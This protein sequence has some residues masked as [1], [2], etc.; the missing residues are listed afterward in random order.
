MI[1]FFNL[2]I[3]SNLTH[4]RN[5]CVLTSAQIASVEKKAKKVFGTAMFEEAENSLSYTPSPSLIKKSKATNDT[6]FS[7]DPAPA[8]TILFAAQTFTGQ[9]TAASD[10]SDVV[11]K[12]NA[13][14][15]KTFEMNNAAKTHTPSSSLPLIAA[16]SKRREELNRLRATSSQSP[17]KRDLLKKTLSAINIATVSVNKSLNTSKNLKVDVLKKERAIKS[18]KVRFQWKEECTQA[19]SF[20]EAAENSRRQFLSLKRT[21]TSKHFKHKSVEDQVKRRQNIQEKEKESHFNSEVFRDHHEALKAERDIQRRQSMEA[22]AKLREN[23]KAGEQRLKM[24]QIEEE[25]AVIEARHD[26]STARRE[27]IKHSVVQRRK[28]FAFRGGDARRI[29]QLRSKWT[30]EHEDQKHSDFELQ[31]QAARDAAN[32]KKEMEKARRESL[33]KR[34]AKARSIRQDEKNKAAAAMVAEHESYQ[35]KFAGEKD[36]EEYQLRI[37]SER[38]KSLANRNK[39]SA[40]HAKVMTELRTLAK[41]KEAESF[42]LKWAGE[43]DA[44]AYLEK[45][46][47]DRRKSLKLR[48]E[49]NKRHLALESEQ[50]AKSRREAMAEGALQSECK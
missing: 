44:K 50:Q 34:N 7:T 36:A 12:E 33:A 18:R 47:A 35:L 22:R 27:F 16:D 38:R 15:R 40:R 25:A 29:R 9:E 2:P 46:S 23:H 11:N 21:L 24:I 26:S 28:S 19:K 30:Q 48:G 42:V 3:S 8:P 5:V 45:L 39:E 4:N 43:A 37:Q 14:D 32:Y 13:P 1:Y 31:Q 20:N 10:R 6:A 41:E 49:E 17:L